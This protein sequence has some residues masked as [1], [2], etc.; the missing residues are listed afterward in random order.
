MYKLTYTNKHLGKT[1]TYDEYVKLKPDQKFGYWEPYMIT[2]RGFKINN[3]SKDSYFGCV[4]NFINDDFEIGINMD[5]YRT[6]GNYFNFRS[7][8]GKWNGHF[9]VVLYNQEELDTLLTFFER[10]RR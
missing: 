9:S 2:N 8:K 1:I 7:A 3:S 6:D 10:K 5:A 4:F